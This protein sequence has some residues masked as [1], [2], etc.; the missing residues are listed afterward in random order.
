MAVARWDIQT[1]FVVIIEFIYHFDQTK[2]NPE[3][4]FDF[5]AD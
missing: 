1:T 4:R 5:L 2:P 3:T